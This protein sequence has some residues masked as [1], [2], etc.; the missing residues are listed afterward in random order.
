MKSSIRFKRT[1]GLKHFHFWKVLGILWLLFFLLAFPAM[2]AT[3]TRNLTNQESWIVAQIKDGKEANLKQWTAGGKEN[4][5]LDV[6][7]LKY[8]LVEVCKN[9]QVCEQ[10][11]NIANATIEGDL[12]LDNLEIGYPVYFNHCIFNGQVS[13]KRSYFKKDLSFQGSKFLKST[14]FCGIK[15]DG[16]CNCIDTIFENESLWVDAKIGLEF[17][18]DGA[19][20][21][22]KTAA[23][24]FNSMKVT[25]SIH[26]ERAKFYGPAIFIRA[27]T[28]RQIIAHD[29]KFLN[30][31]E[32]VI[33]R[34][35]ST[36]DTIFLVRDEFH[37]PVEFKLAEIGM[38]F[39]ATG[40]KFLNA[41]QPKDFTYMK[42]VQK[43]MLNNTVLCGDF[44]FS[45]GKFYD[46]EIKGASKPG[47]DDKGVAIAVLNLEG[48]QL[49]R[50]LNLTNLGIEKLNAI[51]LK[52]GGL[53]CIQNARII[54]AAD[55]RGS[56]FQGLIFEK[57]EWPMLEVQSPPGESQRPGTGR[58]KQYLY[59]VHLGD[60]TF[61]SLSIDKPE[62][63]AQGNPCDSD[64]KEKDRDKIM[65]FLDACPFY[66]QSYTQVE[67]FFKRISRDSWG[68]EVF[69]RMS[70]RELAEKRKWY[71][72]V[73]WLEWFFWGKIAG[74]GR[75][76]FRVFFL[77]IAFIILG[78][79]LFDPTNLIE[80]KKAP[81][82][83][84]YRSAA[85][86]L[87]ISLDRFLP[88]ELGLAKNWEAK[89]KNFFI[90]FYF[91]LQQIIGWILI[92]IALA[93]IYSQFK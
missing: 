40:A 44:D 73:R 3:K 48:A 74:Y 28:G 13:L 39:N 29:A 41:A 38:D 18:A 43:V 46:L 66:T 33:F 21:R 9:L 53:T 71:D 80:N 86:R 47:K 83:S 35:I 69:M 32:K 45:Y 31:K 90:W 37:G 7:F 50:N 49:Q 58:K 30:P 60:L 70:A 34:G 93:S 22:S 55:F 27:S 92:P 65:A 57:V 42:V 6:S 76:P 72:P 10:G 68:N 26:M 1:F 51:H 85:I 36:A 84:I 62:C 87:I 78:A 17:Q 5:S 19:E 64:Y 67:N 82:G 59:E 61:N 77:A 11:V 63:D 79:C 56:S 20:F 24:D 4:H 81:K 91:Y 89:G 23:V 14:N 8:L 12:N 88:I 15:I 54:K 16:D 2:G 25:N 52:V 75:A